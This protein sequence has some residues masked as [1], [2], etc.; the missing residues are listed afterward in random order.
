VFAGLAVE[1]PAELLTSGRR[2]LPWV[3]GGF[4]LGLIAMLTIRTVMERQAHG[5]GGATSLGA[6]IIADITVD[7]IL[8]GLTIARGSRTAIVFAVCLAPEMFLLGITAADDFSEARTGPA[9]EDRRY[10]RDW[11]RHCV[12][13]DRR[14]FPQGHAG[15]GP[16]GGARLRRDRDLLPGEAPQFRSSRPCPQRPG[17]AI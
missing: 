16:N 1:I 4:A 12:W 13:R 6:T 3:I 10:R 15:S 8:I 7:G 5:Q 11:P 2:H 9:A 17:L 14:R